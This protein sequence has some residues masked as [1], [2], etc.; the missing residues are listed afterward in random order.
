MNIPCRSWNFFC[1][2][3]SS[4]T[5]S[6]QL[7]LNGELQGSV[8]SVRGEEVSSGSE[9]VDSWFSIGQGLIKQCK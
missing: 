4:V 8:Q 6:N 3:Y 7:Y 1:W 5:R 2:V 9:V